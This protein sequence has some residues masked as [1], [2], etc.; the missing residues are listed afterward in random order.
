MH[1]IIITVLLILFIRIPA[2]ATTSESF[3]YNRFGVISIY[4]PDVTPNSI[5]LF[6][7]GD[8][9]WNKGEIDMAKSIVKL[10][11]LVVGV[12][13]K[14]YI[15]NINGYKVKCY[16][17]AADFEQLSLFIQKKYRIK[18]YLKPILVGYSAG[19]SLVYGILAQS[20]D[21]TFKGAITLG[22]CP[23]IEIDKPLCKGKSL[24]QHVIKEGE[25][26][27]LEACEKLSA[28]FFVLH[29]MNDQVCS[30]AET[31]KFMQN[32]PW[33]ELVSLPNVGHGFFVEDDWLPQFIESYKKVILAP[34]YT[35]QKVDQNTLLKEQGLVPLPGDFPITVIPSAINDTLP[36]AFMISG[37]GGWTNFDQSLSEAIA[38]KGIPV[39][40]LDAQQY[41]WNVK[42]PDETAFEVTKAVEH[43]MQQ[44]KK[45]SF[46]LIGYSFGAGIVPFISKRISDQLK[47]S[48][49]AVFS[50][51]PDEMC[52]FE[53]HVTDMLNVESSSDKFDVINEI[54]S[55][56]SLNPVCIFGQE[57][58]ET[59]RSHFSETGSKVLVIPG[60]HHYN[61]DFDL[62]ANK[63]FTC[64]K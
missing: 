17:P 19:A 16:Y 33:G 37:D 64:I 20:P 13:F 3:T 12:N 25:A 54:K 36:V 8:G 9:G 61:N 32:L 11:A 46:I 27:Y 14:S 7:S 18:Q 34:S 57:E 31:K 4:K 29:G 53:I 21:N 43:Y 44:W 30:Y 35:Q 47:P 40:G 55:I 15:K 62:I 28:P 10:G 63:I 6:I 51:S 26:Y 56:R 41:F 59:L 50:L 45:N 38:G 48:L 23:E 5:V 49:R 39:I 42:T 2:N 60:S 1:R 22:F 58:N 52:D 24:R